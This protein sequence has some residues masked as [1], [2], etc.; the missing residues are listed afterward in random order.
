MLTNFNLMDIAKHYDIQLHEIIMKDEL[1][2]RV[3]NGNYI[4]NLQSSRDNEGNLNGGSHWTCL[5]VKNKQAFFL[6]SFGAYPSA[7]IQ[8]YVKKRKGCKFA[9]NNK[10]IQDLKSENCG[11]FCISLLLYYKQHKGTFFDLAEKYT[12]L[13]DDNTKLNDNILKHIFVKYSS[14]PYL[15]LIRRLLN[16]K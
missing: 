4:I 1:T 15:Q 13:F 2:N 12:E 8:D 16:Q 9:F 11:Y 3:K 6:D 14:R 10:I 5:I 7:E